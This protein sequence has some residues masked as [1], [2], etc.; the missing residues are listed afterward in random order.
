MDDLA[1]AIEQLYRERYVGFRNA[2]ATVTGSDEAA[3]D[4]ISH[5]IQR[6]VAPLI[7]DRAHGTER[8]ERT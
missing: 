4:G 5:L 6:L 3:R 2:L 8:S 1:R 7:T